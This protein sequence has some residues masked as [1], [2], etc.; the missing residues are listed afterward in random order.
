MR[1]AD[2]VIVSF[3]S[4]CSSTPNG[5]EV[6]KQLLTSGAKSLALPEVSKSLKASS[7]DRGS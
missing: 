3:R 2:V 4:V 6:W 5:P 7:R 1:L